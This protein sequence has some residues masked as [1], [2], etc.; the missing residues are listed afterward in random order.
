MSPEIAPEPRRAGWLLVSDDT[1]AEVGS[2][3]D[4][5]KRLVRQ[6]WPRVAGRPGFTQ[7]RYGAVGNLELVACAVD[8]GLWVGWF[9]SDRID[10]MEGAAVGQ[11]SGALR[12]GRGPRFVSASIT[13]VHAGPD[14]LEVVAL[15][16]LGELRRLVW[17]PDE[18]FVEHGTLAEQVVAASALVEQ[19]DGRYVA[20]VT[21]AAGIRALTAIPGDRY[22]VISFRESK[23]EWACVG[24]A[25][26]SGDVLDVDAAWHI[27]HLDVLVVAGGRPHLRCPTWSPGSP[28]LLDDVTTARLAVAGEA[29]G[30]AAVTPSGHGMLIEVCAGASAVNRVHLGPAEQASIG[31][32]THDDGPSWHVVVSAAGSLRHHTIAIGTGSR[33]IHRSVGDPVEAVVWAEPGATTVHRGA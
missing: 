25:P 13:Q 14:W 21:G 4:G 3:S 22:P 33:Q 16:D 11:W 23:V 24:R 18:G 17:S 15:T 1:T 28:A 12:F 29:T 20:V 32:V 9:N 8:D 30:I 27:D 6:P 26:E 19:P 2:D 5:E 7:G 31:V 10:T